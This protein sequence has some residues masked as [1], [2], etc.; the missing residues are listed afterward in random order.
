MKPRYDC[1]ESQDAFEESPVKLWADD[2]ESRRELGESHESPKI[3]NNKYG[4]Y[5]NLCTTLSLKRD[6]A[7]KSS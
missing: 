5:S 2:D 4:N 1:G 7:T 3:L 6:K